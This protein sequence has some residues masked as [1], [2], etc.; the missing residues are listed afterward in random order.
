MERKEKKEQY[1]RKKKGYTFTLSD[2]AYVFLK[3]KITTVSR[4]A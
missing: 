2:Q 3:N 4:S 1:R